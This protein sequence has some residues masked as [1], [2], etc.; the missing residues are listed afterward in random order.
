MAQ[1]LN[2]FSGTTQEKTLI[3]LDG[4]FV[5]PE[6][7]ETALQGRTD[8]F[9][10]ALGE[11]SPG[12]DIIY[13][14][15]ATGNEGA[16]R[17]RVA[18]Q[19]TA[20]N[21][22]IQNQLLTQV[23]GQAFHEGLNS[24]YEK[25]IYSLSANQLAD[26][27]VIL[28]EELA[29]KVM[30]DVYFNGDN[31]TVEE[32][33]AEAPEETDQIF[34]AA[35][36][37]ITKQ[38]ILRQEFERL[39]GLWNQTSTMGAIGDVL[40]TF[41][42]FKSWSNIGMGGIGFLPG[43]DQREQA[44]RLWSLPANE[45]RVALQQRLSEIS[46]V[47][48]SDAYQFLDNMMN[49]SFGD[50]NFFGVMDILS[51]V[52]GGMI[53]NRLRG[54]RRFRG[55]SPSGP[56]ISFGETVAP[57]VAQLGPTI[58]N[59]AT[60]SAPRA[61]SSLSRLMNSTSGL[62]R[63]LAT[64]QISVPQSLAAAGHTVQAGV[65]QLYKNMTTEW[66]AFRTRGATGAARG[67]ADQLDALASR[68][69]TFN[70]PLA[71]LGTNALKSSRE[72]QERVLHLVNNANRTIL[73]NMTTRGSIERL[74]G[75]AAVQSFDYA[76]SSLRKEFYNIQNGLIDI[77]YVTSNAS[78]SLSNT[79]SVSLKIGRPD[80]TPFAS[81][82]EAKNYADNQFR[83]SDYTIESI[84][85][86]HFIRVQRDVDETKGGVRDLLIDTD[87]VT[88][89]N[90]AAQYL[91]GLATTNDVVSTAQNQARKTL[92]HGVQKSFKDFAKIAR[93]VSN[94]NRKER[95]NFHRF[96]EGIY[97]SKTRPANSP[98]PDTLSEYE[99]LYSQVFGKLPSANEAETYFSYVKA[100]E[101]YSIA[102][103]ITKYALRSRNGIHNFA[104]KIGDE[105]T[106]EFGGKFIDDEFDLAAVAGDAGILF[107][108]S[109]TE[110]QYWKGRSTRAR[111]QEVGDT[112]NPETVPMPQPDFVGMKGS[113]VYRLNG[114]F[115]NE[116]KM[117]EVILKEN[118]Q[119]GGY[120]VIQVEN[121]YK[122]FYSSARTERIVNFIVA[123]D[124]RT[125]RLTLG[126][127]ITEDQF[128]SNRIYD[129]KYAVKQ[130]RMFTVDRRKVFGGDNVVQY[131][132][133]Q[134]E[135]GELTTH[136]NQ[137]MVYYRDFLNNPDPATNGVQWAIFARYVE[138]NLPMTANDFVNL[139]KAGSLS[140]NTPMISMVK[141]TDNLSIDNAN[142]RASLGN[143]DNGYSNT[144]NLAKD[145]QVWDQEPVVKLD[146]TKYLDPTA[147]MIRASQSVAS[148]NFIYDYTIKSSEAFIQEFQDILNRPIDQLRKNP[149]AVIYHLDNYLAP[150]APFAKKRAAR[151]FSEAFKNLLTQ[152]TLLT[153]N[154]ENFN[155]HMYNMIMKTGGERSA[156]FVQNHLLEKVTDPVTLFRS[157]AFHGWLGLLAPVQFWKQAQTLTSTLAI[158]RPQA[159]FKGFMSYVPARI[160][161]R[162]N[163][164]PRMLA[165]ADNIM[166]KLGWVKGEFT[167]AYLA[168][169]NSGIPI[170]SGD[171]AWREDLMNP[172]LT[173][174][175]ISKGLDKSVFFFRE[176]ERV[177]RIV[178]FMTAYQE[179]KLANKGKALDRR[180]LNWIRDREDTLTIN[181]SK[182]SNSRFLERGIASIPQQFFSYSL[183][184]FSLLT[185]RRITPYEK[186]KLI[187]ANSIMY[188]IP[189]GVGG[190][191]F[192]F[193]PWYQEVAQGLLEQD[194]ASGA[195]EPKELDNFSYLLHNGI[196]SL[197][198]RMMTGKEFDVG[199]S[200]GPTGISIFKDM[201]SNDEDG[202]F[203]N[204]LTGASGGFLGGLL[205]TTIPFFSSLR[206]VTGEGN[207]A[208]TLKDFEDVIRNA[209]S[210]NAGYRLY[211]A[212]SL[213][214]YMSKRESFTT[215]MDTFEGILSS[216]FGIQPSALED[217]G[218]LLE[219]KR[220]EAGAQSLARAEMIKYFRRSFLAGTEQERQAF[221]REAHVWWVFGNFPQD[222]WGSIFRQAV[223]GYESLID[224]LQWQFFIENGVTSRMEGNE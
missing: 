149:A 37:I 21:Q 79:D 162:S 98:L 43:T 150:N 4:E 81:E 59:A 219:I 167:E 3:N 17:T 147:M 185:G 195:Y 216:A 65:A 19:R 31:K 168:M 212:I 22:N 154:I 160:L 1:E 209:S 60:W 57:N 96:I 224:E 129:Y 9:N 48:I 86:S 51:V 190:T 83:I 64:R 218:A 202:L 14:E 116:T 130:P 45:F 122:P 151:N 208:V 128:L 2:I 210:I 115:I 146:K 11:Q 136:Y 76:L 54:V 203:F 5:P 145:H 12:R 30:S 52:P 121:P 120:R 113:P 211:Y 104:L 107:V 141:G 7:N 164:S 34:D 131:A 221:Q 90:W 186:K 207:L 220:E 143:F 171:H 214:K 53:A 66:Q 175:M 176:G 138:S 20:E 156:D 67:T 177:N 75:V 111:R 97:A 181:M 215:E 63:S 187:I 155:E 134:K 8:R 35:Q 73:D 148:N 183:R 33:Y 142:F 72:I 89:D 69:P 199:S 172:G 44:D 169:R 161:L 123:K 87:N 106:P 61:Q 110:V 188:G 135:A 40:E 153:R 165:F 42:P 85:D 56:T 126:D 139:V 58:A 23:A 223:E 217:I 159:G 192:P 109:P 29:R 163:E 68:L 93:P 46:K 112:L 24:D 193:W 170:L 26:P 174:G 80:G 119:R 191:M 78:P 184:L 38:E 194:K 99:D 47:N 213:G 144:F 18:S 133:T 77:E 117:K 152:K 178:G 173:G 140:V 137:S 10:Y 108:K 55:A 62:I 180:A 91:G 28:E 198:L 127:Q 125:R 197:T 50:D 114:K 103:S 27:T 206:R 16:L 70:D 105:H 84:G 201:F 189:I 32:A 71:V 94:L 39:E 88:P 124:Y 92:V 118:L 49:Y 204:I 102:N 158:A 166:T 13:R 36:D 157:A 200:W 74:G 41:I 182:A 15:I 132:N 101:F 196:V 100:R 82:L 6:I 25:L 179:Y 95:R 222:Q 205:E